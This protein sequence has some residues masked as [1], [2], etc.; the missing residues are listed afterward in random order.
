M[1]IR[2][3]PPPEQCIGFRDQHTIKG[4]TVDT[5]TCINPTST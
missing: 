2:L 3:E 5:E 4:A 1:I